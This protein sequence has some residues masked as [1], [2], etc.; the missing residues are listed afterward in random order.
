MFNPGPEGA[1][2][3]SFVGS[4]SSEWKSTSFDASS[5]SS[6]LVGEDPVSGSG[7]QFYRFSF[8][9]DT[10]MAVYELALRYRY[11]AVAYINGVEVFRDNLGSGTI[12][13]DSPSVGSY[14]SYSYH[15]V[16]RQVLFSLCA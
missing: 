8:E 2:W 15:N 14:P 6:V 5:W 10:T 1:V 13:P 9:G 11:G 3:K 4:V 7:N 16:I 12:S